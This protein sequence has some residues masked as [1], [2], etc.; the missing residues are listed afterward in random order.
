MRLLTATLSALLLLGC[1]EE[2]EPEPV[3][4]DVCSEAFTVVAV[5][6]SSAPF[7]F[8]DLTVT[9]D[10]EEFSFTCNS[11]RVKNLTDT[12][13]EVS[14]DDE[15]FTVEGAAPATVK[16]DLN[17]LYGDTLSPAY[18]SAHPSPE[19]VDSCLQAEVEWELPV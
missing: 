5:S 15:S 18:Q 14:C 13:Y 17:G 2:E 8:A 1:A 7:S 19:C 11:G 16:V 3:C 6:G 10:G 4:A 12:P 9:F